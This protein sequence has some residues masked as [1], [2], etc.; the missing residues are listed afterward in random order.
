MALRFTGRLFFVERTAFLLTSGIVSIQPGPL[1]C[2]EHKKPMTS[3]RTQLP[4]RQPAF[5][6][7]QL[8]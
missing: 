2:I 6:S 5:P 4:Q 7:R 8:R 3:D 1:F